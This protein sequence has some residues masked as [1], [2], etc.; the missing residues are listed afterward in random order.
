MEE[1]QQIDENPV[2]HQQKDYFGFERV[3]KFIFPDGVSYIEFK[4]MNEGQKKNFQ[5]KT[6]KDVVL[7]RRSGNARMSV[8][9]GTERHELI[10]ASA[11][12]WNLTRGGNPVP[13]NS[14]N[15]GDFLTLADPRLVEDLEKAIRKA[16]PWLLQDMKPED[17]RKEIENLEEMYEEAVKREQG[18]AS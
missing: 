17:I 4:P 15:L 8:M 12:G 14:V 13:F 11:C 1:N 6:S 3:E 18:E 9:A 10:K 5:D 7:E 16:N 2:E